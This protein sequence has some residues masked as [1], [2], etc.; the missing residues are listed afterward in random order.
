VR[1]TSLADFHIEKLSGCSV[2]IIPRH[3][4]L[5]YFDR[6]KN[7]EIDKELEDRSEL[8]V[9]LPIDSAW[10][11]LHPIERLYLESEFSTDDLLKILHGHAVGQSNVVWSESF[12]PGVNR[13]FS[14]LSGGRSIF[15]AHI[16]TTIEGNHLEIAASPKKIVVNGAELVQPDIYAS[17]GVLHT[18]SSLLLPPSSL[19][20]T[21]EKFLL[22][23]KCTRFV[24]LLHSVNLTSL[25]NDPDAKYTILAPVDDVMSLFGD[26]DFPEEGS[27]ELKRA[28]RY[29]FIPGRWTPNKM[30]HKMLLETELKEP[31]LGREPQVI[32]VEVTHDATLSGEPKVRFGGIGTVQDHG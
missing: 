10:D 16:V 28:L 4:S 6:I 8:T 9:F 27:D 20:L 29:H 1:S 32:D 21:P 25:I 18:V 14:H 23:L 3:A 2:T 26:P 5:S 19:R 11:S 30:K 17:N 24:S 7:A 13:K 15:T 31:G 22:A 12:N